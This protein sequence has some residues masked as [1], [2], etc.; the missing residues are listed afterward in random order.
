MMSVCINVHISASNMPNIER[1]TVPP[2]NSI[3]DAVAMPVATPIVEK[4]SPKNSIL[5]RRGE[6][7]MSV[8]TTREIRFGHGRILTPILGV[9]Y[10]LVPDFPA[11]NFPLTFFVDK[12]VLIHSFINC[13]SLLRSR[14]DFASL[15]FFFSFF[16]L[17]L[18]LA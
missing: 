1:R 13:V 8:D 3:Q 16:L 11:P 5:K 4:P 15:L 10:L 2:K 18:F 7:R 17:W 14:T 9:C 6:R 12:S